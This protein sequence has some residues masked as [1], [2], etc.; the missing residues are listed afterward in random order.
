MDIA[1]LLLA[2][3]VQVDPAAVQSTLDSVNRTMTLLES[4]DD[5]LGRLIDI[6]E[7]DGGHQEDIIENLVKIEENTYRI[8]CQ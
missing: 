1:S 5:R 6:A 3:G 7:T 8:S 2:L 4:I